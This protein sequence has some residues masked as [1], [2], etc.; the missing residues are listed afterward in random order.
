MASPVRFVDK[1]VQVDMVYG[2]E[3]DPVASTSWVA[4]INAKPSSQLPPAHSCEESQQPALVPLHK[5]LAM[6]NE[7]RTRARAVNQNRFCSYRSYG[8]SRRHW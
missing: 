7:N 5:N 6:L 4:K 3:H 2:D 8:I 1:C